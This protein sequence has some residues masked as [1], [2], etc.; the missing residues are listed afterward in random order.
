MLSSI[1]A[2]QNFLPRDDDKIDLIKEV[3]HFLVIFKDRRQ[4][5]NEEIK[6]NIKKYFLKN[7][8]KYQEKIDEFN[9]K[10][11]E[12]SRD[13]IVQGCLDLAVRD[14]IAFLV[15]IN[16]LIPEEI[17]LNDIDQF[18]KLFNEKN[19]Q[20][21]LENQ[22]NQL[23]IQFKIVKG[24]SIRISN[25]ISD[26]QEKLDYYT[27]I[28]EISQK[29]NFNDLIIILGDKLELYHN[30][31]DFSFSQQ[32][33]EK[34]IEIGKIT[35]NNQVA[36]AILKILN[37]NEKILS[38]I[39]QKFEEFEET[40]D[41][42]LPQISQEET[43]L[44]LLLSDKLK[45]INNSSLLKFLH[46]TLIDN[47]HSTKRKEALEILQSSKVELDNL[48]YIKET[49]KLEE[50]CLKNDSS[51]V[52]DCLKHVKTKNKLTLNCFE[53]L[54]KYFHVNQTIQTIIEIIEQEIQNLPKCFIEYILNYIKSPAWKTNNQMSIFQLT[55]LLFKNKQ[56]NLNDIPNI[57]ELIDNYESYG[58][59]I[60]DLLSLEYQNGN[61]IPK[62]LLLK[63]K[64]AGKTNE[65][66]QNLIKLIEK[67]PT[68]IDVLRN[69]RI[70]VEA[71]KTALENIIQSKQNHTSST[72]TLLE[73]LIIFDINLRT[74]AFK[75]LIM[76]LPDDFSQTTDFNID[77]IEIG[78]CIEDDKTISI[79]DLTRL[80]HKDR[81][82]ENLAGILPMIISR[83][84]N[85]QVSLDDA[86]RALELLTEIS[87]VKQNE[88]IIFDKLQYLLSIAFNTTNSKLR[89]N[90]V[91]IIQNSV[92]ENEQNNIQILKDQIDGAQIES[93]LADELRELVILQTLKLDGNSLK[94]LKKSVQQG[95]AITEDK[96]NILIDTLINSDKKGQTQYVY[97]EI[98]EI[99]F[100]INLRQGLN[101]ANINRISQDIKLLNFVDVIGILAIALSRNMR[102][103]DEVIQK[104]WEQFSS[105]D[106]KKDQKLK[107]YLI[108]ATAA[109]VITQQKLVPINIYGKIADFLTDQTDTI[110][111]RILCARILSTGLKQISNYSQIT[112]IMTSLKQ[113]ALL[114]RNN[115]N[116]DLLNKLIFEIL[117]N[118]LENDFLKD[119]YIQ[120][121]T[122]IANSNEELKA[123]D[124]FMFNNENI[125]SNREKFHLLCTLNNTLFNRERI[126][127]TIFEQFPVNEWR[128]EILS[129]DLLA[130]T[131]K[132]LQLDHGINEFE[133]E[134]FRNYIHLINDFILTLDSKIYPIE[135]LLQ[136]LIDQQTLYQLP[137]E[138]INGILLM[139][140]ESKA[141]EA[142]DIVQQE[143][144]TFLIQ[145]RQ[146][147][148]EKRL[149]HFAIKFTNEELI[150]FNKYLPYRPKIINFVFTQI[151]ENIKID[152]LTSF[153][154]ELFQSGLT[155]ESRE[156]FLT[157][158]ITKKISLNTL[159]FKLNDRLVCVLLTNKFSDYAQ[160]F[161]DSQNYTL[162][163]STV[164]F[165]KNA[166]NQADTTHWYTAEDIAQ[167]SSEWM[168]EFDNLRITQ[169]LGQQA[170]RDLS[171]ILMEILN[172]YKK[173][174]KSTII[175][176][177]IAEN[178][179]VTVAITYNRNK[180][181]HVVLYKDSLGE[182]NLV[183]ERE[184]VQKICLE[185][186]ENVEFKFHRLCEQLDGFNCG[187][188]TLA[189][190]NYMAKNLSNKNQ[191][192]FIDNFQNS[193]FTTQTQANEYRREQ[194]P[195]MYALSLFQSFKRRKIVN[196]HS[197]ELKFLKS[198]LE[199]NC[200]IIIDE[201]SLF[202]NGL[203]L[204][205]CLPN[206]EKLI[207]QKDYQYLYVIEAAETPVDFRTDSDL[208][209]N[210]QNLLKIKEYYTIEKNVIKILDQ[211]LSIINENKVKKLDSKELSKKITDE[212]IETLLNQ[213][214]V[215]VNQS[216]KQ[217]LCTNLVLHSGW[218]LKSIK[219]IIN[220]IDS[221]N[222]IQCLFDA[223]DPIYEYG[224]KEF[225]NNIQ[226]KSLIDILTSSSLSSFFSDNLTK[227]VHDLAIFQIFKGTYDKNLQQLKDD[228]SELNQ[229]QNISF[230][231]DK[232]FIEEYK[233]IQIVYTNKSSVCSDFGSIEKWSTSNI[234]TWSEK[235]K[236]STSNDI[237]QYEKIAVVKRA[238]EI[239]SKF[240]PRE[241]QLLSV[242]IMLNS[243]K[244]KGRLA[245]IN[246]GEGKTTIVAMLAAIKALEGHQVD[247]VT[248]SPELAT[249]QSIQQKEFY[250]QFNL[251]VSHN[252][253]DPIDIKERYKADIVYGA[254]GN[255]Q[256]DIL[257]DEYSK[258]GTRNGRQCDV[259]IV[260]EVDSMLIDGKNHIV[261][262]SSPMPAMD[263]LEP[264][265]AAI[266][267]QI[268]ELSKCIKEINGITCYVDQPDIFNDDGTIKSNIIERA[269]PINGT[270]ED[271]I[272]TCTEKYIR[273]VIRDV[274]HLSDDEDKKIPEKY[275]EIKIPKHLRQLV[276]E[277]QLTKWIDSAIYAKYR[278]QNEQHYILRDGKI[279][280]V[281]ASN[282]G[283]VQENMHWNNGLHQFLQIKHGAKIS[284][285]SLTTN[286][287]SNVTYFK[288][289]GSNIYGLTGTL[290]SEN[291]Q[292]LLR[293]IYN[294]DSVIIPP[295]KKK[296]YHEL[297]PIIVDNENDWYENIVQS[298][299]NKLI[300]GRGV[301]VIT[302]F[303]KEVDEIKDRLIKAGYS[304]SKIKTYRTEH[305]SKT[306]EE[307][308]TPGEIIIA[309]NI[310]G[311]G[312]DIRANKIEINGG[313]HVLVTFLPPNER[314]EQQNVGRTSRT[315]NKGTGQFILLQKQE[316]DYL[317]LKE[318]RNLEEEI[319]IHMAEKEIER[320]TN[321][322]AIF[323]EFC[324]LLTEIGGNFSSNKNIEF[325]IQI[326]AVE[327]RFGIWLKLQETT[328]TT[329]TTKKEMLDRFKIFRQELL[330]DKKN[331]NL[332]KNPYFHVLIGNEYLDGKTNKARQNAINEFTRAI[333]LDEPFQVN[334]Y[335]NRGYARLAQYGS[336]C[337]KN[338]EEID[339]AVEDFKRAKQIVNDNFEPMLH[340]IQ[341]ASNSEVLSEQVSHK[342]T[343][344]GIQ[345]NTI[346]S[347]IGIGAE[348][349]NSEIQELKKQKEQSNIKQEDKNNIDKQIQFL[350]QNRESQELGIIGQ[351]R[352]K[353]HNIEIEHVEIEQSLPQDQDITFYKEEIDEYKNNGFRGSFKIKEI[354]PIDWKAVIAVAALG[355]S[356]LVAGAALAVFTLGAGASIGMG[357]ITEGV[358]DLITA[359]KDGIINRDFS[360]V[361]Y[362][363]QK[364]ISLTVSLVCAGLGAIKDAAKTAV[365]G[366]KSIGQVMTTT[367]KT[368]WKIAAKAI[369]TGLA[370]GVAKE[371]VTQLVDYGV[372]KTLMPA[373]QDEVMKQIEQPIQDALLAN[374]HVK[375][376]LE[377]DGINRNSYYE[378]LIKDRAM[379]LL[380][381]QEQQDA[382]LSIT[383]GI[384]KGI[385]KQKIAG[386]STV[387]TTYE[388]TQALAELKNF[389][390]DF[391]PKLNEVINKIYKEQKV[392]EQQLKNQQHAVDKQN[393]DDRKEKKKEE[394]SQNYASNYTPE[395]LTNDIDLDNDKEQQQIQLER[396]S[397]SSDVLCRTLATSVSAKMCN[398]IQKKL[399][400]PVTQT[401][402]SYSMTKL[403]SGLDKTLQDK[404]GIYQAERRTEFFQD[405]DK[406][407]R[408]GKEHKEGMQDEKAV[409]KANQM[410]DDLK[411]GGEAGLPHLGP[412]S[413]VAGRPIK[414]LDE[415]GQLVRIIGEDK[416]GEPI[417]VQYHKP[418][419]K[420]PSGHWTLP[421]GNEPTL[422]NTGKNNCLFNVVAQAAEKDPNQLRQ[423]TAVR[424][425]T[426]KGNLANQ[427]RDITR[428]ERD[429]RDALTLGGF[430]HHV[431][432]EKSILDE[433]HGVKPYGSKAK[434]HP[435]DH[436]QGGLPPSK[437]AE[438]PKHT[439][440]LN[441]N[442]QIKCARDGMSYIVG[443]QSFSTDPEFIKAEVT[444]PLLEPVL[445]TSSEKN[446]GTTYA[447]ADSVT[448]VLHNR[449]NAQNK[450]NSSG[451]VHVQTLFGHPATSENRPPYK[452]TVTKRNSQ[453]KEIEVETTTH[454]PDD[455]CPGRTLRRPDTIVN[456]RKRP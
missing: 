281:D 436:V 328:T 220:H 247:I 342:L 118:H 254:A 301:L 417:E 179:W 433:S 96:V 200:P 336:D 153:F 170:D 398:I 260:D 71:R 386:L 406:N 387:L 151:H 226:G 222:K 144:Q 228:I 218:T 197:V 272:K 372:T 93:C 431:G 106:P 146:L 90:I 131:F 347:A 381:S 365:A 1:L 326:R 310:A 437:I 267:T 172:E 344:F 269:S 105:I 104:F 134:K 157:K 112:L 382:L 55:K 5:F 40:L 426:D 43:K 283:I 11:Y 444:F 140:C 311:R 44:I 276:V 353:D 396:R 13:T 59:E 33:L 182:K 94:N 61:D 87:G 384:G 282:T 6:E 259:A 362:G 133:L 149:K 405:R 145:L 18:F 302:K 364:A 207:K 211:N 8:N 246:T 368:G 49:I 290:G 31:E 385:A 215:E 152:E 275:P 86:N 253:N 252:G 395:A 9:N 83:I 271:F 370:K 352:K 209:K 455:Q 453:T 37:F 176:L 142:L 210:I 56:I 421:G 38:D 401:G 327:D 76:I 351:A 69:P 78:K 291:A 289:Y 188:F 346:E 20:K 299:I 373:I 221:T 25:E 333:Q 454:I 174:F 251:T 229:N 202:D 196:H 213:L 445:I 257:R 234:K 35:E 168:K 193:N 119:Y 439:N 184:T 425:E 255:F 48:K 205:I 451:P 7:R 74:D 181:E 239:T 366:V 419:E 319:G 243:E 136:T 237:S 369:G 75:A 306:V 238:V 292:K 72:V 236:I 163:K 199:L 248:S 315:G 334:A 50:K 57:G 113:V 284:A 313:L 89:D 28:S 438:K 377:L 10:L 14:R 120:F 158:E 375:Q 46:Q 4:E 206:E 208:K 280:P 241:I 416:G 111:R 32:T 165:V 47:P 30:E 162:E 115:R 441:E 392:D 79:D 295:F 127:P 263:Y 285:E 195:K 340:I 320:V 66:A 429:K 36:L 67:T 277:S 155:I 359:V 303:I 65:Y 410:I 21:K 42:I 122:R 240:P 371:L 408:I 321:K 180:Q 407:N 124:D 348:G 250:R 41:N 256:G 399:I 298:S 17:N 446:K 404:I 403:T 139:L 383:I 324:K 217:I 358:S 150:E 204:S 308:M 148:L 129:S 102:F 15:N 337:K 286:F 101:N 214:C 230:L 62:D 29:L 85:S 262:L 360:W 2:S 167:I 212:D 376:M 297:T 107:N 189:N 143:Q 138:I 390:P 125:V 141:T 307:Q 26:I 117:E 325:K 287:I 323:K 357:L 363:I 98:T 103:S 121:K 132:L 294:V 64:A 278:C 160:Y 27:R 39:G 329:T 393:T 198:I 178:H 116:E 216:D 194:F 452:L 400:T 389:V 100:E 82:N 190:M 304:Q 70:N 427:A 99:L 154:S 249:P 343:L 379:E 169:P 339:K 409:A 185:Q 173:D 412:L 435:K 265:L 88:K 91:R 397:K 264:L 19:Q 414:V 177:N 296:Q 156:L 130:G 309:T 244:G 258:L 312:T 374:D 293:N 367:I 110:E 186:L 201:T 108:C 231:Q 95:C 273:K 183:Q 235:I 192:S 128:K 225:D 161:H 388:V 331:G 402:I 456:G 356:Q 322:D 442:D 203:R 394:T 447:F 378:R 171:T 147:W 261:M 428:L 338:K 448:L 219:Q 440:F 266:W 430:I 22:K 391:T 420:N 166:Y 318:I 12:N 314:V 224:L 63:V 53:E 159:T 34:I 24:E 335:Y 270:K 16:R 424:M 73:S 109:T 126:D 137:L 54:K 341:Q 415:N 288:R 175:P 227:K 354:K 232:K 332:I 92:D 114:K 97:S 317:K 316:N 80:L 279:A 84:V 434:G 300:N 123:L 81:L 330:T 361:S 274:E 345:K 3:I 191:Q 223:L 449:E 135:N 418:N 242:L 355:L 268:G 52:G 187:V 380:N 233:N 411:N 77:L 422:R 164:P 350:E 45:T 413:D 305:E 58:D 443:N 450:P 432:K 60:F 51:I 68:D 423:E 245:Q 23:E 349:V